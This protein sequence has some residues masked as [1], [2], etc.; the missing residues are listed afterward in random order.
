[1]RKIILL[2]LIV[3]AA[4]TYSYSQDTIK[5]IISGCQHKIKSADS[6]SCPKGVY[7][8]YFNDTL[9]IYGTIDANCCGEHFVVINKHND[10]IYITSLD[11]GTLCFCECVYCFDIKIKE[12]F[13]D[14]IVILNGVFYDTKVATLIKELTTENELINIY[15]NPASDYI[16]IQLP[17]TYSLLP[18]SIT[19]YNSLGKVISI[20]ST[21]HSSF[22]I[23]ISN[24][25]SGLYFLKASTNDE[26]RIEKFVK[27]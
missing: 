10:S 19:I 6:V 21:Q 12:S 20:L 4:A 1:M 13:N 24:L 3:I 27:H 8:K 11:T 23:S 15:P 14:T 26:I 22:S 25:S 9:E 16:N 7:F 2:L 17:T 18:V 5:H